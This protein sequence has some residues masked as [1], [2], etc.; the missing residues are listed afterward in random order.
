MKE[1]NRGEKDENGLTIERRFGAIIRR[2]WP[3]LSNVIQQ[4]CGFDNPSVSDE[5]L[6]NDETVNKVTEST[7]LKDVIAVERNSL[8][9]GALTGSIVFAGIRYLPRKFVDKFGSDKHRLKILESDI[10]RR[11]NF[12]GRVGLGN[13]LLLEVSLGLFIGR[14]AYSS[15]LERMEE[16]DK[17]KRSNL[18]KLSQIPLVNGE[19]V[20]ADEL[21]TVSPLHC[22]IVT[23]VKTLPQLSCARIG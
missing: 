10:L 21:C 6:E 20:I 19:S 9:T 13:S 2:K 18:T 15:Q 12:R 1:E 3:I 22:L 16:A 11:S 17:D 14:L 4:N 7:L 5:S 8:F 23:S